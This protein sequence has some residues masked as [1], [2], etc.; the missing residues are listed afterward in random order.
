MQVGVRDRDTL[1]GTGTTDA[2][3]M[4]H[5]IEIAACAA[6]AAYLFVATVVADWLLLVPSLVCGAIL[7]AFRVMGARAGPSGYDRA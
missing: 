2:A 6:V 7:V 3:G 5:R 1:G 4:D